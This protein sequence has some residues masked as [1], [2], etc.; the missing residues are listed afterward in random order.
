MQTRQKVARKAKTLIDK[1]N[2]EQDHSPEETNQPTTDIGN[3]SDS[4]PAIPERSLKPQNTRESPAP[5]VERG[6]VDNKDSVKQKQE[7]QLIPT[8]SSSRRLVDHGIFDSGF[9][10]LPALILFHC[11]PGDLPG[12]LFLGRFSVLCIG[13][14]FCFVCFSLPFESSLLPFLLVFAVSWCACSVGPS[15]LFSS[16]SCSLP[17]VLFLSFPFPCCRSLW[18]FFWRPLVFFLA[19]LWVTLLS[20]MLLIASLFVAL[21]YL[22]F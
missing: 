18:C 7:V 21:S 10:L 19:S 22:S 4:R 13:C 3:Q 20:L 5:A 8:R 1:L 12:P 17:S 15:S 16:S 14:D 9:V 2:T 6:T 11:L